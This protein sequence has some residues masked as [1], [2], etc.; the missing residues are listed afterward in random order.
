MRARTKKRTR[1]RNGRSGH[2]ALLPESG[3]DAVAHGRARPEVRPVSPQARSRSFL[4]RRFDSWRDYATFG[5]AASHDIFDGEPI[6][7]FAAIGKNDDRVL[8]IRSQELREQQF[9]LELNA[10]ENRQKRLTG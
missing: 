8:R 7:R 1:N 4:D 9:A 5:I 6:E 10:V 2:D 3:G